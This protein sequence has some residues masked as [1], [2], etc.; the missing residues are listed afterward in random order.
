MSWSPIPNSDLSY[1]KISQFTAGVDRE[2]EAALREITEAGAN[3][4]II[5]DLRNNPGAVPAA[6]HSGQ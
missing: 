2:L 5:L 6:S 4:G 3:Q 1:I